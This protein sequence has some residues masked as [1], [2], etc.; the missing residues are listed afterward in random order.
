MFFLKTGLTQNGSNPDLNRPGLIQPVLERFGG[1]F[2][3]FSADLGG[4][5][6]R[7]DRI[8]PDE[9]MFFENWPHLLTLRGTAKVYNLHTESS[10]R[11]L[12]RLYSQTTSNDRD[13]WVRRAVASSP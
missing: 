3:L 8:R 5:T 13:S 10:Y 2:D 11:P 9:I 7:M 4:A 12:I 1:A 6:A